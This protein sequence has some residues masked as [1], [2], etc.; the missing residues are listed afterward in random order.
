MVNGEFILKFVGEEEVDV[1][2]ASRTTWD[3]AR[4]RSRRKSGK[5]RVLR[6]I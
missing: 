1:C 2:T 3:C 4:A 5:R 6:C